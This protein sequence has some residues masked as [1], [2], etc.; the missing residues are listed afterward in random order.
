MSLSS[1]FIGEIKENSS[2]SEELLRLTECQS[3]TR[4]D[5]EVNHLSS[6]RLTEVELILLRSGVGSP[7]Q[8]QV[9]AMWMCTKHRLALG[10]Q[11][12]PYRLSCH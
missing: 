10:K 1:C 8:K 2:C 12:R 7:N 4:Y 11:W 3:D 9:D 5:L 6:E